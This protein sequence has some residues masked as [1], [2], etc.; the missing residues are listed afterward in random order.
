MGAARHWQGA[1][2]LA[3]MV[4]SGGVLRALATGYLLAAPAAQT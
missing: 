1:N 2:N 4:S 3:V